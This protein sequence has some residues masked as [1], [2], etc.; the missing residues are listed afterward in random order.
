[1]LKIGKIFL[2]TCISVGS[3]GLG[4]QVN[5]ASNES[6]TTTST[7]V[8]S[9]STQVGDSTSS[10]SSTTST[11][12]PV[13]TAAQTAAQYPNR[14]LRF[15]PYTRLNPPQLPNKSG[16]GR[17]IIYKNNLQWVWVV[18][19]QNNVVRVMPVS[20][21][22]GVP[23]P[24]EYKVNS[25]S[26]RS[27]SLDFAGVWFNNMT[28]FALGPEGG[29]IGFHAIPTKNGKPLQTEDELG[30]FQGSGCLRMSPED[31]K[32][33]YNFAKPGTKVVVLP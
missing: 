7:T 27:Y 30:S 15:P 21:R 19:A 16:T 18:D 14:A 10:S 2:A 1:M 9:S 12:V 17:R 3:V 29:N 33:V 25:Q 11:V 20:G 24:G 32:F 4:D 22:R 26:L 28:R 23:T 6:S 13:P 5:G 8:A 31:A